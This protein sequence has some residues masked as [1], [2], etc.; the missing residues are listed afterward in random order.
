MYSEIFQNIGLTPNEAKIYET[1]IDEGETG[2]GSI[3]I[4]SKIHRRNV[5]DA[6]NRLIEK[7][8][9]FQVLTKGE[10][11]YKAVSPAKLLEII[12]EKEDNFRKIL[13]QL[14]QQYNHT[15]RNQAAFIYRGVE[16]FKNYLR[17]ILRLKQDVFFISS[18]GLWFDP[19]L[20]TFLKNFLGE[21][22]KLNINYHYI[23]D[24]EVEGIKNAFDEVGLTAPSQ[25]NETQA[26]QSY[27]FLP[28]KYSTNSCIDIFGDHVVTFT[29]LEQGKINEELTIYVLIDA[30]LADSYRRWFEFMWDMLPKNNSNN[31][32]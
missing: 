2:V 24:A 12:R 9:V 20:K 17:D 15:P 25:A 4:K 31:Q 3:A 16:G 32:G 18:K 21:A 11:I 29:G 26:A 13:P 28:K 22:K 19:K 14:E 5:Y 8:L 1:L 27:K 6:V 10:N 23:F 30:V 7:G